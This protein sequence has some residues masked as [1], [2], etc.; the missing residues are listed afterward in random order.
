V[1]FNHAFWQLTTQG[2]ALVPAV[3]TLE[4]VD[5]LIQALDE[6]GGHKSSRRGADYAARN[7]L[8]EVP[9]VL[10]HMLTL[11]VHLDDCGQNNGP[12]RVLPGSHRHGFLSSDEVKQ[13]IATTEGVTCIARRGDVLAM[14]PLLM[15]ASSRADAASHRRVIHLEYAGGPLP[16]GLRWPELRS[17]QEP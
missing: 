7:L 9:T 4:A 13:W 12:L 5:A 10:A 6:P 8:S 14:R 17:L 2:F 1:S 11:R 3:L 15:H 16:G